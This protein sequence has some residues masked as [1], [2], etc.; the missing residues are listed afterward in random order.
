MA[1]Y[2]FILFVEVMSYTLRSRATVICGLRLLLHVEEV[3]LDSEDADGQLDLTDFSH[4]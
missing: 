3:L 2:L 1:P 4:I